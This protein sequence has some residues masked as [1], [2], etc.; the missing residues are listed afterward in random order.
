MWICAGSLW[1]L[2]GE[3]CLVGS[4]GFSVSDISNEPHVLEFCERP[5]VSIA[6][7][8]FLYLR[9]SKNVSDHV[10]EKSFTG[11][12]C[13]F[14]PSCWVRC[15]VQGITLFLLENPKGLSAA[16][17]PFPK[18]EVSFPALEFISL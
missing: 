15:L 6:G 18:V 4:T 7:S 1:F 14:L 12:T 8:P 13:V 3:R 10:T 17:I 2:R 5:G 11:H 16:L 9:C